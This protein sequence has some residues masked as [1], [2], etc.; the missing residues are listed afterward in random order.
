MSIHYE[1]NSD[2][3]KLT[4]LSLQAVWFT[5]FHHEKLPSAIERYI[6]EANR[7]TSVLEEHLGK[8]DGASGSDGPWLVG[9]KM[10]YADL[11]FVPWTRFASVMIGGNGHD[12][13]LEKY[14][15][16]KKWMGTMMER[17]AVS[18]AMEAAMAH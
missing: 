5:K 1:H 18:K 7:V 17:P 10:S 15:N 12:Y 14:P 4:P 16:V 2:G 11:A 8:Q 3:S 13:D 6:K 9:G